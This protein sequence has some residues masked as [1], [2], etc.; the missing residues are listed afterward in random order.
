[1]NNR[2]VKWT[3]LLASAACILLLI[4][5]AQTALR[6]ARKGVEI[7]IHTIIP[8]LFPYIFLSGIL[9]PLLLGRRIPI[10]APMGRLCG[11]P[12]GAESLLLL[13]LIGGYPVGAKL[14]ADSYTTGQL[15]KRTAYRMLGFCS[16]AG[17]AF[18][19]GMLSS[20]FANP[21]APWIL[22]LVHIISAVI[23]GIILP[24][25]Q[26][27]ASSIRSVH[28]IGFSLVL[29]RAIKAVG[30]VCGWVILFRIIITFC[31]RLFL[32][33]WPASLQTMFT[34]LLELSNG[35]I[36]LSKVADERIRLILCSG[37]LASGGLC[38]GMQTLSV[39][40]GLGAGLYFPGKALQTLFSILLILPC[41]YMLYP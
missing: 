30:Q 33:F 34:G 7:S 18:I 21:L 25:K 28:P 2:T 15:Q 37:L 40:K 38:V 16:N 27:T 9:N 36:T 24:G 1:M 35:C 10:M 26:T 41:S 4:L 32:L 13:G 22:W 20:A 3:T 5:D 11:V 31:E 39:T 14:I 23:V 29:D 19:F 6:G 12:D 17:P 8:T